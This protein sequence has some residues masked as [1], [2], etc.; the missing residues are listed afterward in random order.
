MVFLICN[1]FLFDFVKYNLLNLKKRALY[2]H[3]KERTLWQYSSNDYRVDWQTI[4]ASLLRVPLQFWMLT[5]SFLYF[6]LSWASVTLTHPMKHSVSIVTHWF[7]VKPRYHIGRVGPFVEKRGSTIA[8]LN[9]ISLNE[10]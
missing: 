3:S 1:I 6:S 10:Y 4:E 7:S 8:I 5:I 2:Y 9:I